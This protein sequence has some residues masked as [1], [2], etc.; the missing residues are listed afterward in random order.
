MRALI[1]SL[2][3]AMP[4]VAE[5]VE[6]AFAPDS[7]PIRFITYT[8]E[9]TFE[10]QMP[11]YDGTLLLDFD[12]VTNSSV[13]VS[14]DTTK[15]ATG[16]IFATQALRGPRL[17]WSD[18]FPT[19]RFVSRTA[20]RDGFTAILDGDL[21]IRDVTKPIT[22]TVE[23]F[24]TAGSDPDNLDELTFVASTRINRN[25]FGADGFPNMV[26]P[27]MDIEIKAKIQRVE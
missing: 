9:G 12:N 23:L 10:G 8:E 19:V 24:R 25:D 4:A 21:T 27:D 14:I 2:F 26:R 22:L 6:Y 1:L 17:L 15:A 18:E 7:D 16:I 20:R 13:D 11:T 3:M 5:Q